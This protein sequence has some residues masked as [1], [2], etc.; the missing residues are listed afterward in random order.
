MTDDLDYSQIDAGIRERVR[1][2]RDEGFDTTDS[3]DGSK[4]AWMEGA[5]PYPMI[6]VVVPKVGDLFDQAEH[7]RTV[8]DLHAECAG[9]ELSAN[10]SPV[11]GT[12]LLLVTWPHQ[13]FAQ[14]QDPDPDPDPDQQSGKLVALQPPP[15]PGAVELLEDLLEKARRGHIT[16]V[17]VASGNVG[18]S[19]SSTYYLGRGDSRADLNMA[20]DMLKHRLLTEGEER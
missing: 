19:M 10:Y 15:E 6:A 12:S 3:G 5:L 18:R 13:V 4:A 2:L 8:L 11:D 17:A 20:L 7:L 14:Q 16:S 9:Y 1:I